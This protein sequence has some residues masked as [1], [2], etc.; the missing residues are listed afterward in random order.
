MEKASLG[1][2]SQHALPHIKQLLSGGAT[3]LA[4]SNPI[5][6][7]QVP[8]SEHR[9]PMDLRIQ[10][11]AT[12]SIEDIL[13]LQQAVHF[14]LACEVGISLLGKAHLHLSVI[15]SIPFLGTMVRAGL[16]N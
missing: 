2:T 16:A 13:S 1:K 6:P 5:L 7:L 9:Q 14:L 10:I 12:E 11:L 4:L 3:L 8:V 15:L